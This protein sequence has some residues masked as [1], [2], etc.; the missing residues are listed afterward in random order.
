M[1]CLLGFLTGQVGGD[2]VDSSSKVTWT[3]LVTKEFRFLELFRS[4]MLTKLSFESLLILASSNLSSKFYIYTSAWALTVFPTFEEVD[5][6]YKRRD[7]RN[8][9]TGNGRRR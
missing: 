2:H 5:Y 8:I 4:K 7:T 1:D 9:Y 6:D 3:L